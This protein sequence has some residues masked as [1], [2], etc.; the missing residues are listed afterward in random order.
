MSRRGACRAQP[1]LS[2]IR[3]ATA[4][5]RWCR[6]LR[7]GNAPVF[8]GSERRKVGRK[9]GVRYSQEIGSH[10][11]L[12][13]RDLEWRR[14][15]DSNP[16]APFRFYKLQIPQCHGCRRRQRCRGALHA[17][18]RWLMYWFGGLKSPSARRIY[19]DRHDRLGDFW[20]AVDTGSTSGLGPRCVPP[21]ATQALLAHSNPALFASIAPLAFSRIGRSPRWTTLPPS[22]RGESA[23]PLTIRQTDEDGKQS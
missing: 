22:T 7:A 14:G 6:N 5:R 9:G 2:G 8:E 12:I 15:W 21:R 1:L 11:I 10:K 16:T 20:E 23:E 4:V 17:I 19:W 13:F 3:L 18:A